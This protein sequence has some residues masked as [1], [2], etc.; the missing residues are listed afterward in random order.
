MKKIILNEVEQTQ[1]DAE[2]TEA[3][4]DIRL[5][6]RRDPESLCAI[7]T[8]VFLGRIPHEEYPYTARFMP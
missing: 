8:I 5:T 6:A 1:M 7:I 3:L 4:T 2:F